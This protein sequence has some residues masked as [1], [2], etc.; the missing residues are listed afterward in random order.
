MADLREVEEWQDV[1]AGDGPH[2]MA[3]ATNDL[4]REVRGMRKDVNSLMDTRLRLTT[5]WLMVVLVLTSIPT[6]IYYTRL[7]VSA[8][9]PSPAKAAEVGLRAKAP[10]TV[11]ADEGGGDRVP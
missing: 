3:R 10:A 1:H 9:A 4:G 2:A 7:I 6:A 8:M 5:I 11:S